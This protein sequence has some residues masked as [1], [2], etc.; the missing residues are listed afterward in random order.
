[1]FSI[2]ARFFAVFLTFR[3]VSESSLFRFDLWAA[4]LNHPGW[5]RTPETTPENS[6]SLCLTRQTG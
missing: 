4:G 1:M 6:L 2:S 3:R 5:P